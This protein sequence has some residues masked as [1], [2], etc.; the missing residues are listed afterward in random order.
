MRHSVC[1]EACATTASVLGGTV[2]RNRQQRLGEPVSGIIWLWQ[3][4][5]AETTHET[6]L[7]RTWHVSLECVAVIRLLD[8]AAASEDLTADPLV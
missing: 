5:V 6:L 1:Q 7:H 4:S 3:L 2:D 8:T